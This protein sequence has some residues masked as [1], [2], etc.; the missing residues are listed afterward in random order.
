MGGIKTDTEGRCWDVQGQWAG[1]PGLFAAGETACVSLHGGN[2]LGANSLLD[3][4]VFGRRAGTCAAEYANTIPPPTIP[5]SAMDADKHLVAGIVSR[6]GPGERAAALRLEMG[7]T[8]NRYVS[9]FREEEGIETALHHIT[10]LKTRW[11]DITIQDKGQ[12]FNTGLIAALELGFMLDCAEAII[13]GALTRQ[14]SRGAHFRTDFLDRDDE[15]WLKHVL[16]YHRPDS[17]PH[18]EYLPV[19][20]TQW[21]PQIRVY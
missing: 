6:K 14:E 13:V 3:T 18:V 10:T 19:R 4:V 15:H 17:P 9:V 7:T 12:V 20:I 16:L 8:M 2:R 5:E 1:V 11:P 21:Q